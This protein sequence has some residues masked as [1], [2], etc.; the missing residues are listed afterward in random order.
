M[1]F[2]KIEPYE[3]IIKK[4]DKKEDKIAIISCNTCARTCGNGGINKLNELGLRL[5]R[6]GYHITDEAVILYA[7]SEPIL[8]EAKLDLEANTIIVLSCSAGWACFTRNF[9]EKKVLKVTEDIGLVM[10]DSDKE[11]FKIVLPYKNHETKLGREY[12]INTGEPLIREKI[13]VRCVQ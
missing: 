9:P 8:R 1:I 6:D 4:L 5:I 3:E 12:R 13:K 11:I 2:A 7:C 10:T